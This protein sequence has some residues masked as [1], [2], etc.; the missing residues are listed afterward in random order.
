MYILYLAAAFAIGA[1]ISVQP[2]INAQLASML[3]SPLLAAACSI[4][5]SLALILSAW[6]IIGST[7]LNW[8][9]FSALPWWVLIGGAAGALFVLGSLVVAPKTGVAVFFVFVVLGQ[10]V[11]ATAIDQF[12]GY[13]TPFSA[14][15]WPRVIGILLVVA[16]ASLTQLRL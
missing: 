5:V 15:T 4:S 11:G 14:I 7:P 13:E 9:R 1:S 10:L 6:A 8:S 3:G 2:P 12:A 16:G